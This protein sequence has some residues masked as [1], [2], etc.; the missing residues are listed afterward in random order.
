MSPRFHF[1]LNGVN[2]EVNY[3]ILI[4]KVPV[5]YS[6]FFRSL[7]LHIYHHPSI[8]LNRSHYLHIVLRYQILLGEIGD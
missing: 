7:L 5:S 1:N 6:N 8:I 2:L 4:D 3:H